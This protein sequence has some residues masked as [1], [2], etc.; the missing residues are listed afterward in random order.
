M[1]SRSTQWK[2]AFSCRCSY[3]LYFKAYTKGILH[4]LRVKFEIFLV[5]ATPPKECTPIWSHVFHLF[6]RNVIHH[7]LM[8]LF[9][10]HDIQTTK[11][12]SIN[13]PIKTSLSTT[14]YLQTTKPA[15]KTVLRT[16][17][18]W[19]SFNCRWIQMITALWP[20]W[21]YRIP[22]NIPFDVFS[23]ERRMDQVMRC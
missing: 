21:C 5:F 18:L 12:S 19:I 4:C 13:Q 8:I 2:C 16:R 11:L 3:L 10:T 20:D 9:H 7:D 14:F 22:A 17:I 6:T 23:K 15:H 1:R